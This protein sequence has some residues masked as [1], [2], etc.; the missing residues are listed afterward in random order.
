[1][2]QAIVV[3]VQRHGSAFLTQPGFSS[4]YPWV[5]VDYPSGYLATIYS[6]LLRP[7]ELDYNLN[8]FPLQRQFL[9]IYSKSMMRFWLND[10][11]DGSDPVSSWLMAHTWPV[12]SGPVYQLRASSATPMFD[13]VHVAEVVAA[14]EHAVVSVTLPSRVVEEASFVEVF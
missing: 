14:G 13:P 11:D 8:R 4:F 2:V 1:E 6:K 7:S 10:Q 5:G 12:Y 3:N 9:A